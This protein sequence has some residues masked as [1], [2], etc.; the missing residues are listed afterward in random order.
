MCGTPIFKLFYSSSPYYLY[1][2][3]TLFGFFNFIR[4][5]SP[6]L[7]ESHLIYFPPSNKMFQ[8][9]ELIIFF[10]FGYLALINLMANFR[11]N[12]VLI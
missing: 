9:L 1:E 4:F 2:T 6:L 5:R 10:F 12:N 8:F 7:T 11:F 3:I